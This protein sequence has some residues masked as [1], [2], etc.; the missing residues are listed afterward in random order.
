MGTEKERKMID[1]KAADDKSLIYKKP[2]VNGSIL[3]QRGA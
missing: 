3:G 2:H 1:T